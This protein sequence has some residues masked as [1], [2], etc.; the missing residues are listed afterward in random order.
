MKSFNR[1]HTEIKV[2]DLTTDF[3]HSYSVETSFDNFTDTAIISWPRKVVYQKEKKRIEDLIKVGDPVVIKRGYWPNLVERF[4]GYVARI[5]PG[6]V[7]RVECEDAAYLCKRQAINYSKKNVTVKQLIQ[8][9]LPAGLKVEAVEA[10]IGSFR[11]KNLTLAE[12]LEKVRNKYGLRSWFQGSTLICG[13]P[14]LRQDGATYDLDFSVHVPLGKGEDLIYLKADDVKIKVK[15][16]SM[17]PNNTKIEAEVGDPDGE[18]RTYTTYNVTSVEE[19]KKVA[20]ENLELLKYEGF[21]GSFEIFGD[22]IIR[23]GD[24][25]RVTNDL[26]PEM[27]KGEFYAVK[28]VKEE[29]GVNTGIRQTIELGRRTA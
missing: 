22:P 13:L 26:N 3:V 14:Y 16:V 4:T 1:I 20:E 2:G 6:I 23:H 24:R 7:T 5:K 12:V 18:T 28:G 10:G 25:V 29:M 8:D 15:A 19:L 27:F 9:N 21:R 17:L 11:V